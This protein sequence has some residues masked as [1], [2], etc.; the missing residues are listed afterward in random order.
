MNSVG[1]DGPCG[2]IEDGNLL[3]G[4]GRFGDDLPVPRGALHA[5]IVRSPH[6]HAEIASLDPSGA[7]ALPGIECVVTGEDA[8]RWTRPFAVALKTPMEQWCLAV[9][10]VRY[11]GEPVAVVLA[12]NRNLAEDAAE[13][14]A[15]E[16]RP[17]P[18]VVDPEAAAAGGAPLLHPAAGTNLIGERAFRY[19]DPEAAF[20]GAAHRISIT[21]R[22]PRNTGSPIECFFVLAEY[23]AGE[24]AYEVTVNFQGPLAMHPVMA[25]ALRVPG[26][27]LRLRTPP[28]SGG[29]FGAKHAVFPYVVLLALAARKAGRPVKWVETRM[30]HLTAATSATNRVTTLTAAVDADGVVTALDWDQLEDCGAYLRAPEP[31]T[32]YRMHGSMTGAYR[33]RN[34]AIRNRVV[35]TNKTPSGLVRGF[36]GPQVYFAL[37]RL[38]QRIAKTLGL[39]PLEVIRRNLVREFPYRCPAGAVLDSGDYVGGVDRAVAEGGLADLRQRQ[40]AARAQGRLYGI[41]FTAVV[42]PSISNMGYI[43]TVLSPQERERAGPKGG[44]QAAATVALDPLGGVRVTIDSLPQGQGHRSVTAQV[45]ADVFGLVRDEVQVNAALDTAMDAWSIAAGNYS[46]RFAGATAGA[47]YLAATRLKARLVP[48]AAAQLN[49]RPD[50]L[51]FAGGRIFAA[52]NP[53]NS[54]SFARIAGAGHWSPAAAD[55]EP[56]PLRET[57]FWSSAALAPPN[58]TDEINSSA[59]Y[60]FVFDFCGVEIDR[61]TGIVRIDKYVS[62][63]DAGRILDPVLFDGQVRGAFAMAVGAALYERLV[64]DKDGGL[65]TGSLADYALPKAAMLPDGLTVLHQETPSPITPLGAKGVAEGNSMSTPV[66]IANAVADALGA[67]NPTLPLLPEQ[68]LRLSRDL[69]SS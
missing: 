38:M 64:Y 17:L 69:R 50:E 34:L 32:L 62:L 55:A 39:D 45:V 36:G 15:V 2:R 33:V 14:V 30:E 58:P 18:A 44:A 63:H 28:H 66:C 40:A 68:V 10:R 37:E 48:L 57:V 24:D 27:R 4:R 11:V 49:L 29:S 8:R 3:R 31:A 56:P 67:D 5:V 60:G 1:G 23:S 9:D 41:G 6:P 42:E 22:Y 61:D 16:Y 25:M 13:R 51:V 26:N 35:L 43:T 53:Q 20:A 47:A 54:V 59:V 12:R 19:G 21:A 46:S 52:A 7:L 65:L